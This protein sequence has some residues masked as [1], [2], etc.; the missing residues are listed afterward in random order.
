MATYSRPGVYISERVL[1]APVAASASANAAG[2]VVGTFASGPT[3]TTLVSSWYEFT[4]YFGG[5]NAAYPA[6]FQVGA[7]FKN[8]GRDLY[9]KRIVA[10]DATAAQIIVGRASLAAG[11]VLTFTA[12]AVGTDG[13]NL[14]V[15][16]QQGTLGSG[17]YDV[18]VYQEGVTGTASD[19]TNDVLLE[20]YENVV[21]NSTTSS[22]YM[23]TAINLVSKYIT[24]TVGDNA[25]APALAVYPLATGSNGSAVALTDFQNSTTGTIAGFDNIDRPLVVFLPALADAIGATNAATHIGEVIGWAQNKALHFVVVETVSGRTVSQALTIATALSGSSYSAVYY[26]NYYITDPVGRSASSIRLIGPA[27]AVAGIYMNTDATVGPFKAPAGIGTIVQG[28]ISLEKAF[29]ST[30]LDSLN[31]AT[32]P[33]NAI[34][35]LPGAGISVMGARTLKQDGTANRYV[36]MRRSLIYIRKQLND[37]TQFALFENNDEKLWGRINVGLTTFLNEYYNQGGLRG[38]NPNQAFYIKC[39][40]ENNPDNLIAQGQVNIEVG[41][42]LQYPAEFIVIALSQKTVNS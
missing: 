6:T 2:A 35:Q 23:A 18:L 5:Y 20:S 33:V 28:A 12:K 14:R 3:T 42:A 8:G 1:P 7:F 38:T 29:T 22:D 32:N 24:V 26:P 27:G 19:V 34:R 9:V 37:L 31:S 17:Y 4:K 25:N 41:V 10:S 15:K 21:T 40:A 39:D 13:N 16:L 30:E 36:N 11:T